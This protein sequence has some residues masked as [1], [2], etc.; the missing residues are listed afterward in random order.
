M[1]YIYLNVAIT[2]INDDMLG[3]FFNYITNQL[4]NQQNRKFYPNA[5][6]AIGDRANYL[7][8]HQLYEIFK[9]AKII[10]TTSKSNF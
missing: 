7:N 6:K 3:I 4:I 1:A 2:Y 9:I 8:I 10:I 5:L